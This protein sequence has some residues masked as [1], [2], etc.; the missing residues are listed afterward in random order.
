M[1]LWIGLHLPRLALEVFCPRWSPDPC[2]V[3]F[4]RKA[5]LACSAA[6]RAAGVRTG[7]RGAGVQMLAP[8]AATHERDPA[9]ETRALHDAALVLLRY[10]P[11]V[12]DA[13]EAT[14]LVDVG[15]SLTLFGGVRALCARIRADMAALG[16]SCALGCAPA[17]RGAWLLA[18]HGRGRVRVLKQDRLAAALDRLPVALLPPAQPYLAW[19]DGIGCGRLG[20]LRGL[21]RPALQRRCGAPLLDMLD[22]AYGARVELFEW[23]VTPPVFHARLELFDRVEQTAA[24]QQGVQRLLLQMTGWLCARQLAVSRIVL[25][26]EHERGRA[27][28]PPTLVELGLAQATWRDAH[29]AR[30]LHEKLAL[31]ALDAPV[32]ALALEACDV[33][34][35]APLNETLFP[36]PSAG[37]A[38]HARL[39]EL[40]AARLGEDNLLLPA[41]C[42]DYR[43]E[44]A[45]GWG[46]LPARRAGP[47]TQDGPAAPRP[48]WLL[49]RPVPLAMRQ[50]QLWHGGPLRIVS[51]PERIETGWWDAPCARDYFVA[52][53]REGALY[54]IYR[55]RGDGMRWYLHGLFA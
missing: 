30:L 4:E 14:L 3:V 52:A 45:N 51:A 5:V 20:H 44:V 33:A 23:I 12:T 6:A 1:Q 18:R 17:A 47:V 35:M 19:F 24:L 16:F 43:P 38:D 36:D 29:P 2:C 50:D 27:V 48:A 9:R 53:D 25:A 31:L 41:P 22:Q 40:L 21:P 32:I 42:A 15:A 37:G 55:E 54:W 8:Q 10:S 34:P 26:L 39:L 7:M 11:Q 46:P 28:R 49:A 13:G